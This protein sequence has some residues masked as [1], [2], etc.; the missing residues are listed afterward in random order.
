MQDN[1]L[2]IYSI[3]IHGWSGLIAAVADFEGLLT[4]TFFC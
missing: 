1:L 4:Y 3:E 2:K